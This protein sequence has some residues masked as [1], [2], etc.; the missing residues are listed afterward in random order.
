MSEAL[1]PKEYNEIKIVTETFM[2]KCIDIVMK[3][4]KK[5]SVWLKDIEGNSAKIKVSSTGL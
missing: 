3:K 2:K 5:K 4:K 1:S